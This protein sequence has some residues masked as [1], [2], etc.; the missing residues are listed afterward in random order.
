VIALHD[1]GGDYGWPLDTL[2]W[3]LTTSWS[4]L[5]AHVR[6]DPYMAAT[7]GGGGGASPTDAPIPPHVC[8]YYRSI[9]LRTTS[10]RAPAG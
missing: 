2:C 5:L 3:A 6:N 10:K 4:R 8:Y 9:T 1:F 7:L